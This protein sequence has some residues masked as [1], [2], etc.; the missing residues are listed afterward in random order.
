MLF[1]KREIQPVVT[2]S[3]GFQDEFVTWQKK[4]PQVSHHR[5]GKGNHGSILA[6]APR[7]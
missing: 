1:A 7:K 4:R 2:K 3:D 6:G 5:T